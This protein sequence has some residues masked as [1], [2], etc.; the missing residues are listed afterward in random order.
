M[1]TLM[2][3]IR[4]SAVAESNSDSGT[5]EKQSQLH[6]YCDRAAVRTSREMPDIRSMLLATLGSIVLERKR[7]HPQHRQKGAPE[8]DLPVLPYLYR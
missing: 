8:C 4:A 3:W 7:R 1:L 2:E 5:L 6:V